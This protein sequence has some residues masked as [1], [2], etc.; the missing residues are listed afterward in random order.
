MLDIN[1]TLETD[2]CSDETVKS[3]IK[4]SCDQ[5][6][7][8]LLSVQEQEGNTEGVPLFKSTDGF[9]SKWL[10]DGKVI[11]SVEFNWK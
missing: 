5:I 1:I 3:L 4:L 7:E 6:K 8:K 2:S 11:G 9:T 10:S